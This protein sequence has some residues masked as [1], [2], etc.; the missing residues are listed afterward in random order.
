ML[1]SGATFFFVAASSEL[2]ARQPCPSA[3]AHSKSTV[4]GHTHRSSQTKTHTD[5]CVS[6]CV[7]AL[8]IHFTFYFCEILL[9]RPLVFLLCPFSTVVSLHLLFVSLSPEDSRVRRLINNYRVHKIG[10]EKKSLS[11]DLRHE[12]DQN[13][14]GRVL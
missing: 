3:R 9:S 13:Y 2:E 6:V 14:K 1:E 8:Q 4:V 5:G 10:R 7:C 12:R 11:F